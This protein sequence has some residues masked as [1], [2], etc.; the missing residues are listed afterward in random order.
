MEP[1]DEQRFGQL[2][3]DAL[4]G[5]PDQLWERFDN[6]AVVVGDRDPGDPDLLGIYEGVPLTER[7]AY[8]GMLPDRIVIYRLALCDLC[9]DDAELTEQIRITV[10]HEIAHHFGIDDDALHNLGWA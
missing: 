6:V 9:D 2:V 1:L 10:V 4:D 5:I 8:F 7:D 3:G